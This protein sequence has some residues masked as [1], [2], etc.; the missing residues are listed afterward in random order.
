MRVSTVLPIVLN[1]VVSKFSMPRLNCMKA[2]E[3]T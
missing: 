2:T 3:N 1:I